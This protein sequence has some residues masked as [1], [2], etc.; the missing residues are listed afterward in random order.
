VYAKEKK[1]CISPVYAILAEA[2]KSVVEQIE[3]T[4]KMD[5]LVGYDWRWINQHHISS[6]GCFGLSLA[7]S[8]LLA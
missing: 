5:I 8:L 3:H 6:L 4:L 2:S 1:F 7:S